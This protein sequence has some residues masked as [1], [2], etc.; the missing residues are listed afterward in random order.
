MDQDSRTGTPPSRHGC[1]Y[2]VLDYLPVHVQAI[3]KHSASRQFLET[4]LA[5][6]EKVREASNQEMDEK[7]ALSTC[8]YWP[9]HTTV[10]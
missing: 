6:L 7:S 9:L 5:E 2:Y 1:P 10:L 3:G 8:M 4:K